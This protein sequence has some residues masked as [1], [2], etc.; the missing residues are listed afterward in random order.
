MEWALTRVLH[1]IL[2][3]IIYRGDRIKLFY[4]MYE[5]KLVTL[6]VNQEMN[7]KNNISIFHM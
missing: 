5:I 7:A 1:A 4:D 6:I 2:T 3:N